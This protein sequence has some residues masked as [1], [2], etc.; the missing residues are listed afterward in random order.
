MAHCCLS[1]TLLTGQKVHLCRRV[2]VG[3]W[4]RHVNGSGKSVAVVRSGFVPSCTCPEESV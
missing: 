4:T 3:E 1:G 2:S